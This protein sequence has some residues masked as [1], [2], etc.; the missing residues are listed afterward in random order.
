[1]EISAKYFKQWDYF[2]S[3]SWL[4]TVFCLKKIYPNKLEKRKK[5][6][7]FYFCYF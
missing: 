4:E 2:M 3:V 7:N 1:M 6:T 5:N